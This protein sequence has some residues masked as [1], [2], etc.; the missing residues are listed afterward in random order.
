[1]RSNVRMV[2]CV[3]VREVISSNIAQVSWL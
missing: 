2:V 1:M 3:W